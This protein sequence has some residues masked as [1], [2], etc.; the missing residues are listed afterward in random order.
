MRKLLVITALILFAGIAFGQEKFTV[1]DISPSEKHN[2]TNYQFWVM[3]AAGINF[4]KEQGIS[5]Y[6][7]GKH[8]G[9]LFAPSWNKEAGFEG[10]VNGLIYNWENF[11]SDEDGPMTIKE[12]ENG[13]VTIVYPIK[14]W[15]KYLPDG[16]SLASFQES[17]ESL[18]GIGEPI[19]DYLGCT[20]ILEIGQ[21][22]ILFTIDK[23]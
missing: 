17:M 23:K 8:I 20:I 5:P 22:S 12:N 16:N 21:E 7:Y 19:A 10:F 18:R 14:A 2:R 13:S 1:P 15:K 11:K 9:N 6:D 4:A 3:H